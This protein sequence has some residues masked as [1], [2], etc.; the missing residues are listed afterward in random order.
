MAQNAFDSPDGGWDYIYDGDVATYAADGEAHASLDGTWSHDNGSDQWDGSGLGGDFGDGNRPGGAMII[1]DGGVNYLRIQ[2]T[3]DPRD[4]GYSDPGSNRKVYLGHNMTE[5]GASDTI[6][7]DGV[8]LYFRARIPTD[9]PLDPL[10]RNG[11]QDA[12]IQPYPEGGD[13]Y[14]T[15][16]GGKGNFVIKQAAGGAIAF[17]LAV[18]TDT[19]NGNPNDRVSG[20]T[21]LTMN[22][23]SGATISGDV[24]FGQ[25]LGANVV[26]LDPTAWHEYWIVIQK[27]DSGEGTHVARI[28]IDGASSPLS[29]KMTAGTGQEGDFGGTSYIAMG[30]TATPQNSALDIDYFG[31]KLAAVAPA[32][33]GFGDPDGGW[34]YAYEADEA[35]YAA[36]GDGHASLDGTWSHDNGSDQ[37]DGSGI[38]G[39]FGDGNRP[40]GAMIIEGGTG[41]YLRIQ[42]TGDPRDYGY[43]DPG[44]NR[45]VYLGHNLT[46]DGASDTVMDDGVTLYFRARIP[47][48]GPLDP[49]HRNG[50]QDAG[51]Q[52]YPEGGDGYVT[53]D[54]GKGNFVI[55]QAAGGAIAFSLAVAT[56]TPNGNPNDRVS[57]FTGLTMNEFSGAT[58]SGDVNFGQGLGA[59]VV[60]LDPTA[61]HDF[62]I[63]IQKDDSGEGTHLARIY[64]DGDSS[65]LSFKMT[66]GTGQE[67]DFGG[68]S[69]LAMGSTATPQNS[70]LDI[71][72]YRV[73]FGVHSPTGEQAEIVDFF[74][75]S[76]S[77][78]TPGVDASEGLSF[79]ATSD[80]G[81]PQENIQ[82][83]LN[84]QDVSSGLS[85]SGN[86]QRWEVSYNDL[87][88]NNIYEG[89]LVVTGQ[90]GAAIEGIVSFD[91]FGSGNLTIEGE[92]FNFDGGAFIND[93]VPGEAAGPN[94]YLDRIAVLGVDANDTSEFGTSDTFYRLFDIVG[95]AE[96]TDVT[97]SQYE[98]LAFAIDSALSDVLPGEWVNYTRNIPDGEWS[99]VARL[100]T[101]EDFNIEVGTINGKATSENQN[102]TTVGRFAG[103]STAGRYDYVFLT[104]ENGDP[105]IF[106][107]NGDTTIRLTTVGGDYLLNYFFLISAEE[108]LARVSGEGDGGG[109][110]NGGGDGGGDV[111]PQ[112]PVA[113]KA[114]AL[115]DGYEAGSSLNIA[116]VSFHGEATA[117]SAD[118]AAVGFTEA[119]DKGYTDLL[120]AAGHSVTRVVTSKSPDV[121]LMNT[122]DLVIISRAVSSGHYSG[123]GA[124]LWSSVR[125]PTL[126]L[127]GYVLRTSR[128]GLTDGTTMVDSADSITV[129]ATDPGHPLF[130]GVALDADGVMENNFANVLNVLDLVQRGVSINN[131]QIAAG[132]T[133]LATVA[134]EGDPTAGGLIAGEW[135]AGGVTANGAA[136]VLAGPRVVLLTGSR[137]QGFTSQGAGVY[138]LASED[139]ARLFL[140]AVGYTGGLEAP[141]SAATLS[142]SISGGEVSIDW[143]SGTLQSA[144]TVS[145]PWSDVTDSSPHSEA[146]TEAASFYRVVQ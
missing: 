74:G 94:N 5:K 72:F 63:T 67:G 33:K 54:G 37:W 135:P 99:L 139:G 70:A 107:A 31:Y 49:L 44:S 96:S 18:A 1:E 57:G 11:Q 35:T 125:T 126:I 86:E 140:N 90:T 111:G 48:D 34:D 71:D 58:I 79:T 27:D 108:A 141:A 124:A 13:G 123:D 120:E 87:A 64:I 36:D 9:G 110:G 41:S 21:G 25:G 65:P 136:D 98:S 39:E 129:K 91:T 142:I 76:P 84:G 106:N 43:S 52:P 17:S 95:T 66:A 133:V 47:T 50:Q 8:T 16:D 46:E 80:L 82:V 137:E 81:I 97:R 118:A 62:W 115:P 131:N 10:H 119:S 127:G 40:G 2:D 23:F 130:D 42:D 15:S 28:Y 51:I 59:N 26:E 112:G 103:S 143:G 14:V 78:G 53:S 104:D 144:P 128:L 12:G 114:P 83:I 29:F 117:A 122:F 20:F 32:S 30:S 101:G 7:D 88:R 61:W 19:P 38:G 109:D 92:D 138:D 113:P 116:F 24:N 6:M 145:G 45:K 68:T 102:P 75:L 121:D 100:A 4:Y 22:E 56:D 146:A 77:I 73:K 3:G 105:A 89:K 132:G 85:F 60:E 93:P 69:Y 134:T 55:K